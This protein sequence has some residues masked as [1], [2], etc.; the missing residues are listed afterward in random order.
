M[1]KALKA[2]EY[3]KF[4]AWTATPEP[5][6]VP[7]TQKDFAAE[8]SISAETLSHWKQDANFWEDVQRSLDTWAK[9][10][11]MNAVA[12]VYLGVVKDRNP[13]MAKIWFEHIMKIQAAGQA[14]KGAEERKQGESWVE[15]MTAR[16]AQ[17]KAKD[18]PEAVETKNANEHANTSDRLS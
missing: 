9:E 1:T 17:L 12:S 8:N 14:A 4:V 3:Y 16:H 15:L 18:N 6:R 11:H 2:Y 5:L 10:K 7:A 13:Y